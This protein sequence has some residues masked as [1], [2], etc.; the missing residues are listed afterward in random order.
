MVNNTKGITL[1]SLV[2]TIVIILIITGTAIT[3]TYTGSDYKKYKLMCADTQILEDKILIYYNR[4]GSLPTIGE[5][6]ESGLPEVT[7][8]SHDYYQIDVS[9]LGNITLNFGDEEDIFI[10]DATTF[11]V[12][13]L[14]GIEYAGTIYYTD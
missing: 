3:S 6:I 9:K 14:N 13:Y 2:I 5:K 12:Y 11:D 1:S 4:Y 10:V 7:N 8:S